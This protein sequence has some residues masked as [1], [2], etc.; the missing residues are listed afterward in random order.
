MRLF[1]IET[2]LC[3]QLFGAWNIQIDKYKLS[4][5]RHGNAFCYTFKFII[6]YMFKFVPTKSQ[7]EMST[8]LTVQPIWSNVVCTNDITIIINYSQPSDPF[9][10]HQRRFQHV[11]TSDT[12]FFR[13]H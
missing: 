11:K 6:L 12:P 13:H 4:F 10:S 2:H 5:A 3:T 1:N 8:H 9:S 7:L